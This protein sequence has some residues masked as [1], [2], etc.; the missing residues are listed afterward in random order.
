MKI[1]K[2]GKETGMRTQI[3]KIE[4]VEITQDL[5]NK[6]N[7]LYHAFFER[8]KITYTA[9]DLNDE[10]K[11]KELCVDM[12]KGTCGGGFIRRQK[13]TVSKNVRKTEYTFNNSLIELTKRIMNSN[14]SVKAQKRQQELLAQFAE[15]EEVVEI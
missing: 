4:T 9:E 6:F 14:S 1:D 12:I 15:N 8:S 3:N 13:I 2:K 11:F 5:T 10:Y 7:K